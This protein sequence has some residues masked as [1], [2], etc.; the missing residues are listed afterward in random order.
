MERFECAVLCVSSLFT[1]CDLEISYHT[2]RT[3]EEERCFILLVAA[4]Q[5]EAESR[6][7]EDPRGAGINAKA[8]AHS[9]HD[10]TMTFQ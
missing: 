7:A 10:H 8:N 3:V 6:E 9:R 1:D 2:C 5:T 4:A